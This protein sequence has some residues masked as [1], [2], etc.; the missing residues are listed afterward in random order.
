VPILRLAFVLACDDLFLVI[1]KIS[2]TK[3]ALVVP[4]VGMG[5]SRKMEKIYKTNKSNGRRK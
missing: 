1:L 2:V 4:G 3:E 5:L